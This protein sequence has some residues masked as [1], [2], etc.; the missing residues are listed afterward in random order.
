VAAEDL[1]ANAMSGS[2]VRENDVCKLLV[3]TSTSTYLKL[4]VSTFRGFAT[5][6]SSR[7]LNY[8]KNVLSSVF[9]MPYYFAGCTP[10]L[11]GV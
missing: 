9:S 3:F 5:T 8:L 11:K 10:Y 2:A 6:F 1:E 7:S 4:F